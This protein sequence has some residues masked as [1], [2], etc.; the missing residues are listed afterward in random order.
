MA[1]IYKENQGRFVE[2]DSLWDALDLNS[3]PHSV[4]SLVGGGGKTSTLFQLARE[5][6]SMGKR[7]IVTTSTRMYYPDEYPVE[8]IQR[9]EELEGKKLPQILVAAGRKEKSADLSREK[10]TGLSLEEMGKLRNYCDILLIEADGAKRLPFKVPAGHEPVIIEE[11]EV[12]IG[13]M[14]LT[15]MG[16]PWKEGCFRWELAKPWM[17]IEDEMPITAKDAAMVLISE[18]GTRKG[19][20]DRNYRILL[21][22]M[23]GEEQK[24]DAEEILNLV[25][26]L[27]RDRQLESGQQ[28]ER[29]QR[30]ERKRQMD[31]ERN[32]KKIPV[33]ASC[34]VR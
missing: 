28:L 14:G 20:G 1:R 33:A 34:Y 6:Q 16:K 4:I 5:F 29:G 22:Q 12:V 26:E 32:Q 15:A 23:D 27:E 10:I 18:H 2:T 8:L 3:V 21:N 13:C 24:A 19:A 25:R 31:Q 9:A 7:V 11:T 30:I 17:K